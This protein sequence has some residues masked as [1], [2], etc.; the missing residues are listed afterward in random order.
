LNTFIELRKDPSK[1]IY[2]E[3]LM[4][5]CYIVGLHRQIED[6][7]LIWK[8]KNVDFDS[9]CSVD[10]PLVVFAGVE[11]T[12]SYLQNVNNE[13]AKAALEYVQSCS[14]AGDFDNLD[15]YF[16]PNKLPWWI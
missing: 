12:S 8:A 1:E 6:C 5:G 15:E 7:L 4:L 2:G 10:I 16:S 11:P 3:D 9:Y 14:K 13:E